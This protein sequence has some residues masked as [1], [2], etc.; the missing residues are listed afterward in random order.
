M[1]TPPPNPQPV[2]PSAGL[3]DVQSLL[4]DFQRK[5]KEEFGKLSY[6][7]G[8]LDR[9]FADFGAEVAGVMGQTQM[10]IRGLREET[11]IALPSVVGL[12]GTLT[13]VQ[14]IQLGVTKALNT[15]IILLGEQASD[16]FVASKAVGVASE[17]VG[18]M[19][20][21]FEN[22]GI[23]TGLIRDNI[24]ASVDVARRVG[25]NTS[26][27]FN[28]VQENL[29]KL[30][31]YGFQNGAEG[32]ARMAATSAGLRL[33]MRDVFNFAER[34]FDPEG[35]INAVAAFQR[36]GVAAGDLADPFRLMYLASEDVEELNRQV[37]NMTEQFTYFDETTKEFKVFPN[38]KRDLREIS[39][40]TGIAYEEMI[41]MSFGQQ[42]LNMI[43]KDF[44]IAGIDEDS[45][46]FVANV[47]QFSKEKGAFT[48]KIG[49]DEKLISEL[50]SKDLEEI[51][52]MTK[53]PV[54]LEEIARAQLDESQLLN[55]LIQKLVT[56]IAAP[57]AASRGFT[58]V[59]EVIRGTLSGIDKGVGQSFGN[60]RE[61]QANINKFLEESGT[62]LSDIL[63]GDDESLKK[64]LDVLGGS[65]EDF[66]TGLTN[67]GKILTEIPYVDIAQ[68]YISSGNLVAQAATA[69]MKGL[70]TFGENA[71]NFIFD[72]TD[73]KKA[74][75][76]TVPS[77]TK[78]EFSEI[79]YQGNVNVT[80]NTPA[81]QPQT[82]S[83]TDQMAYDLFQNSTF[84]K[85][86]QNALQNAMSQP[87]YS[88]LP[89]LAK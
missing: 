15:N 59:R 24:Q 17:K 58:D 64:L 37:I 32:L 75:I 7:V 3:T 40:E 25:V 16:L 18:E 55:A 10:A 4:G 29:S 74:T 39:K 83:I 30:N 53:E 79:K 9:Q 21:E 13:D 36:L 1:Q 27:V 78:V 87:Q 19:A 70:T 67:V 20:A 50:D 65:V 66:G 63:G 28:L 34:V 80:L 46:Q 86:N 6:E 11:A 71:K 33:N 52:K 35:A 49:K 42:K 57:T 89:N 48:V 54:T 44:R 45:K 43:T 41:K 88:A 61:A 68:Q 56:S 51:K 12:G 5:V 8:Y 47:A 26:A 22:A 38:A 85:L 72:E 82:F 2:P 23:S 14:N 31:E 81:G 62:A 69:A 73:T 60:Q 84:Q 76:T 77:A